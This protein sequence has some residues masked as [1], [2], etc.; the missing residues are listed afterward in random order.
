MPCAIY[1]L[2]PTVYYLAARFR[3][4]FESAILHAVNG[5]AITKRAPC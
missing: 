5:V 2:L 4:D 3:Q 1:N